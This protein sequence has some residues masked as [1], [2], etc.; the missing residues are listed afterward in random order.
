MEFV[1]VMVVFHYMRWRWGK[2]SFWRIQFFFC[3][4]QLQSTTASKADAVS[5]HFIGFL[6][7]MC[8]VCVSLL[9]WCSERRERKQLWHESYSIGIF[10]TLMLDFPKETKL[11]GNVSGCWVISRHGEW[12]CG[13]R[14]WRDFQWCVHI[15]V[16]IWATN[17]WTASGLPDA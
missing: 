17:Y 7:T 10:L 14:C 12:L 3:N 5:W 2:Y 9:A 1:L 4:L 13:M 15:L 6:K 11:Y 16:V 8:V